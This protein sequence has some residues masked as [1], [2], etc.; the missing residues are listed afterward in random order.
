[1]VKKTRRAPGA[2]RK[3]GVTEHRTTA[4]CA[5]QSLSAGQDRDE[6]LQATISRLRAERDQDCEAGRSAGREDGEEWAHSASLADLRRVCESEEVMDADD[7]VTLL[8]DY[9]NGEYLANLGADFDGPSF[10]LGYPDGFREGA[11]AVWEQVWQSFP[12]SR[13]T[14]R[15]RRVRKHS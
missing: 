7:L 11:L 15:A 8:S 4:T 1:M 9:W 2:A 6:K 3:Q 14:G 12:E 13:S 10:M 5:A